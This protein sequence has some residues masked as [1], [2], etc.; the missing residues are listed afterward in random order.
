MMSRS[1]GGFD[2]GKASFL[3]R[4]SIMNYKA[5]KRG[6]GSYLIVVREENVGI[7]AFEELY[8][9]A[10]LVKRGLITVTGS[11]SLG[12][13][14]L[15]QRSDLLLSVHFLF[16]FFKSELGVEELRVNCIRCLEAL[17]HDK[18]FSRLGTRGL[19]L[20]DIHFVE[21]VFQDV[22]ERVVVLGTEDL[23]HES[24]TSAENICGYLERMQCKLD[25]VVSVLGPFRSDI[26]STVVHHDIGLK[27][28]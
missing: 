24:T 1:A 7:L 20:R 22:K 25:L 4:S 27:V 16:D 8:E 21:K 2:R 12:F 6:D 19:G 5:I 26:R 14:K 28:L 15:L 18:D 11:V 23:G 9:L 13:Q 3:D 10:L 17:T